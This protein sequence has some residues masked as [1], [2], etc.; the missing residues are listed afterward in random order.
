MFEIHVKMRKRKEKI[1]SN[2]KFINKWK[3]KLIISDL[4]LYDLLKKGNQ[5]TNNKKNVKKEKFE[6]KLQN[7]KDEWI[8]NSILFFLDFAVL[9]KSIVV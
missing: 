7:E 9:V 4:L 1:I 5:P 8:K 6:I 3:K 2:I